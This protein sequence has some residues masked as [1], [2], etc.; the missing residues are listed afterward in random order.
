[1]GRRETYRLCHSDGHIKPSGE[2]SLVNEGVYRR[3]E[4]GGFGKV[5]AYPNLVRLARFL[6]LD[7]S[8]EG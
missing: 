7:N 3:D 2:R 5:A 8:D 6:R 1:M 4:F